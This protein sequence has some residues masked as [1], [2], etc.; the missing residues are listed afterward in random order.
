MEKEGLGGSEKMFNFLK[1]SRFGI[2]S[3]AV[4]RYRCTQPGFA[5]LPVLFLIRA[6][7]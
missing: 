3:S 2:S 4:I 6:R 5:L 7:A 1:S